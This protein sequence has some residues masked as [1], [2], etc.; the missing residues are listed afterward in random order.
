MSARSKFVRRIFLNGLGE[1]LRHVTVIV[2][3]D[4]AEAL[5]LTAECLAVVN[6][7]VVI[8]LNESLELHAQEL[9]V[10]QHASMMIG[11][12]PRPGIDVEPRIESALLSESAEL[13][14]PIAAP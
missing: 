8:A 9:A 6:V 3:L 2:R 5:R 14:V 1:K 11:Q 4:V 13:G 10:A 12:A 7:G